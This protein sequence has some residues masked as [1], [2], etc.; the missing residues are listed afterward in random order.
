MLY[1]FI[2]Q[3]KQVLNTGT[4]K[5]NVSIFYFCMMNRV[6]CHRD[7]LSIFLLFESTN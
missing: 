5:I 7:N 2:L 6:A 3:E 4:A 1:W